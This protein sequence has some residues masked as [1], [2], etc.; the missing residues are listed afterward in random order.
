MR[1]DTPLRGERFVMWTSRFD[2]RFPIPDYTETMTLALAFLIGF[3]AGARSLT[4]PAAV[5]WGAHLGWLTLPDGLEFMGSVP[6]VA[7]FTMLAVGELCAD[8]WARIP[9]RTSLPGLGA[10]VLTGALA[11]A[12]LAGAGGASLSIG[13]VL[14]AAG[15]IAGAYAGY[16]ARTRT[17]R[18]LQARDF[19]VAV[20]ED[21]VAVGGCFLIVWRYV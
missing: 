16:F 9:N 8:K 21:L 14:G 4:P 12:C 2:S 6:A 5:A 20:A 7:T 3:F 11:G 10:R 15:G 1:D 19:P 13:A 17:V 18:A